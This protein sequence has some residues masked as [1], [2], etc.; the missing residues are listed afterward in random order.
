MRGTIKKL[1][2]ERG[3]GF[4]KVEQGRDHFFHASAVADGTEFSQLHEGQ[5]VTFDSTDGE[6][7]KRAINVRAAT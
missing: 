3:F 5:T 1:N 4:I 2:P 7:G 6:R